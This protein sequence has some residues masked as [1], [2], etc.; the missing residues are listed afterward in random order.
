MLLIWNGE[1][2]IKGKKGLNLKNSHQ[3]QNYEEMG[4]LAKHFLELGSVLC[5]F[6]QQDFCPL[7]EVSFVVMDSFEGWG[8]GEQESHFNTNQLHEINRLQRRV[9]EEK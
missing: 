4:I 7:K 9:H 3:H 8:Y 1:S 2:K 6:V 5:A